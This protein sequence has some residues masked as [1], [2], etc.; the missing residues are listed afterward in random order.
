MFQTIKLEIATLG[1]SVIQAKLAQEAASC[2][3]SDQEPEPQSP[4]PSPELML[5]AKELHT[6][7]SLEAILLEIKRLKRKRKDA[8]KADK[9]DELN[10]ALIAEN[11]LISNQLQ[12]QNDNIESLQM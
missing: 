4:E 5:I 6:E 7:P 12:I 8:K 11:N 2:P 3:V 1:D 9:L 10:D